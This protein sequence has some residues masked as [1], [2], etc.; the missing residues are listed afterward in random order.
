MPTLTPTQVKYS[1]LCIYIVVVHLCAEI[2]HKL[3]EEQSLKPNN[4]KLSSGGGSPQP[5][6]WTIQTYTGCLIR[7]N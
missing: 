4:L 7:D 6:G 1:N 5:I 3:P 2:P